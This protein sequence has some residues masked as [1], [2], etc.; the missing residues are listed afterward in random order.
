MDGEGTTRSRAA[1]ARHGGGGGAL[2]E[3]RDRAADSVRCGGGS[4]TAGVD[5]LDDVSECELVDRRDP[6]VPVQ[7]GGPLEP[8]DAIAPMLVFSASNER[9]RVTRRGLVTFVV[10]PF[11]ED[12]AGLITLRARRAFLARRHRRVMRLGAKRFAGASGRTASVRMRLSR[13]SLA[14]LKHVRKMR[15]LAKLSLRDPAGNV[16]S[17]SYRVTLIAPRRRT[18]RR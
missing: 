17:Q 4:D 18:D 13:R 2:T 12:V 1:T 3:R 5:T 6:A 9:V 8:G 10:G 16:A 11:E 7:P 15:T 14:R